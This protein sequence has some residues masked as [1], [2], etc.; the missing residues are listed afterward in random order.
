MTPEDMKEYS[1]DASVTSYDDPAI[2]RTFWRILD[3]SRERCGFDATGEKVLIHFYPSGEGSELFVTKLGK[4]PAEAERSVSGSHSVAFLTSKNTIYRFPDASS[5][6]TLSRK[7]PPATRERRSRL[8]YCDDDY[9]YL[10]LEDRGGR[11]APSELAL[12]GECARELP[13]TLEPYISEHSRILADGNALSLL[14][15]L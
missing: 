8:Y 13:Y 1:L 15:S 5:L 10:I 2:R 3:V 9:Y 6:I 4:L 7:L 12:L 11:G 14:A